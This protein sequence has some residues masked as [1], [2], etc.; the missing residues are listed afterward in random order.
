M[1]DHREWTRDNAATM[2]CGST[3]LSPRAFDTAIAREIGFPNV[4]YGEDYAVV[5]ASPRL[6]DRPSL[7]FGLSLPQVEGN[8]SAQPL[9]P[10]I[11]TTSIRTDYALMKSSLVSDVDR[12]IRLRQWSGPRLPRTGGLRESRMRAERFGREVLVRHIPHRIKARRLRSVPVQ[13]RKCFL[14]LRTLIPKKKASL[15]VRV[16]AVLQ[17]VSDSQ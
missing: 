16:H 6:R 1:I 3:A 13:Q 14:A 7:R 15:S 2:R 5:C 4:S 9:K 17:S 11:A 10:R 8:D 12:L